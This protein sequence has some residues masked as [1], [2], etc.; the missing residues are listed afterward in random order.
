MRKIYLYILILAIFTSC[1]DW[2]EIKPKGKIIPVKVEDYRL[3]LDQTQRGEF[4]SGFI[5]SYGNVLYSSD[6]IVIRDYVYNKNYGLSSQSTYTWADKYYLDDQEDDVWASLY[7][8]IYVANVVISEVLNTKG[9]EQEKKQLYGEAKIQ[10]AFAYF[11]LTNIY[12]KHYNKSTSNTDL[13]V[14]LS[15][16]PVIEGKLIRGTVSEAYKLIEDD[17]NEVIDFL[18]P[19][20]DFNHRPSKTSVYALLSRILLYKADY[21]NALIAANKSLNLYDFLYDYNTLGNNA[22]YK[23]VVDLPKN[24]FNKEVILNKGAVNKYALIY[25]SDDLKSV[26]NVDADLRW[27]GYF[28]TEWFP[29][30]KNQVYIM[31]HTVGRQL[32]LTVAEVM[33]NKAECLARVGDYKEAIKILND[34]RV[35]RFETGKYVPLSA[36]DRNEAITKVKEERRRELAFHGLRWFDLKRY[37]T[38]DNAKITLKRT[39]NGRDYMLSPNSNR[40]VYPIARKYIIKNPEIIQ[41]PR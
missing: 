6:D 7:S 1:S 39:V 28:T 26:Y 24:P 15:K 34:I 20:S 37:N 25:P 21:N 36:S 13:S 10:R 33:L 3:L 29:P 40:W 30:Y 5:Q 2:L 35:K 27:K 32:G 18:P 22:W 8:Q 12:G 16:E 4:S 14:P 38:N 41:N 17:I 11:L 31:E 9:N 19:T 23:T